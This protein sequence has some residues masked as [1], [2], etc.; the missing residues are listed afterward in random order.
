M[1][2][3]KLEPYVLDQK[4]SRCYIHSKALNGIYV[5]YIDNSRQD[6]DN[7]IEGDRIDMNFITTNTLAY[8]IAYKDSRDYLSITDFYNTSGIKRQGTILLGWLAYTLQKVFKYIKL[9]DATFDVKNPIPYTQ[10]IY[11]KLGFKVKDHNDENFI[12][13]DEWVKGNTTGRP[14]PTE[15]RL[16]EISE[17]IKNI[18]RM[19]KK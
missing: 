19:L 5:Y 9:D 4:C 15:E 18:N 2:Y 16:I 7:I 1:S 13:Y 17:L 14:N 8:I 12:S 10:N 6:Y 3:E 11:Y